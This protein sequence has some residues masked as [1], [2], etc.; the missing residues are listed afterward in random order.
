MRAWPGL[1]A[2]KPALFR[3]LSRWSL[4]P[5]PETPDSFLV[6][7]DDSPL[8]DA[9]PVAAVSSDAGS[10]ILFQLHF[11]EEMSCQSQAS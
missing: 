3:L 11:P 4:N 2:V 1:A 7:V 8:L 6:P 10:G 5:A 9:A